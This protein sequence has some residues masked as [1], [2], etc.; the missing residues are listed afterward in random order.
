MADTTPTYTPS[1]SPSA[2][3]TAIAASVYR[4]FGDGTG[5]ALMIGLTLLVLV[6]VVLVVY[7]VVYLLKT[8][9]QTKKALIKG[10]SHLVR[11]PQTI[12]AMPSVLNDLEYAYTAWVYLQ[13][14]SQTNEFK[15]VLS[16][17]ETRGLRVF[18]DKTANR[19]YISMPTTS[20]S[21]TASP[22]LHDIVPS[23]S[24]YAG[25]GYLTAEIEYL[26]L[27]RWV[28]LAVVVRQDTVTV[29]VNGDIYTVRSVTGGKMLASVG[30]T[31]AVGGTG[32]PD[33][34]ISRLTFHNY[35]P[36]HNQI[37]KDFARGPASTWGL[38]NYKLRSPI[39]RAD[40]IQ[41]ESSACPP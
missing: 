40:E 29:F 14:H 10:T 1:A 36:L 11:N 25:S 9:G 5:T 4:M 8:R 17:G 30:G 24:Q 2:S 27:Q 23:S 31:L 12:S 35:A 39:V 20:A 32:A 26:P 37:Q 18:M 21:S 15:L 6:L 22:K 19:V 3:A 33:A 7:Y 16:R 13:S 28:H 34:F 41:S 38:G